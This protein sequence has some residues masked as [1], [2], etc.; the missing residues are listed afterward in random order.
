MSHT[1]LLLRVQADVLCGY[2]KSSDMKNEIE[3]LTEKIREL[4]KN[5][6]N[7]DKAIVTHNPISSISSNAVGKTG[8]MSQTSVSGIG[9]GSIQQN[10]TEKLIKDGNTSRVNEK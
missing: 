10:G 8:N 3:K 5:S 4:E 2:Y 7:I 6:N 9:K 1:L